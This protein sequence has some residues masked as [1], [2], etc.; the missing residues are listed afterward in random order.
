M[1]RSE[2]Q[3]KTGAYIPSAWDN[4]NIVSLT[5]G[6]SFK[7][8]WELGVKFRFSGGSPYTPYDVET[9]AL[10]AVWDVTQQGVFDYNRLNTI[11]TPNVHGLDIRIDKKWYLKKTL[12]NFYFDIQNLY[13]YAAELQPTLTVQRDAVGE[14]IADPNN[15]GSYLL[16]ELPNSSGTLLPSV[17]LLFEF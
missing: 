9:T 11:R 10:Q 4:R 3:D 8:N 6:K 17:G 1:V 16:S 5:M 14:P 2:F 15:P 7:K 13:G 12:L